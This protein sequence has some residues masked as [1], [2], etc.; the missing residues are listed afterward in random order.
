MALL[1]SG[2]AIEKFNK[3][4]QWASVVAQHSRFFGISAA[5]QGYGIKLG[6]GSETW[7]V[8]PVSTNRI[9]TASM[10]DTFSIGQS[11]NP[12]NTSIKEDVVTGWEGS[13]PPPARFGRLF[14]PNDKP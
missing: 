13:A 6:W 3:P 8:V 9:Y 4:P 12:F 10:S 5:Y 7:S 11:I 14:S 1:S 2:C